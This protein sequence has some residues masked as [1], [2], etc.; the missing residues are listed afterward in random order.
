MYRV[1][2]K[3]LDDDLKT[4]GAADITRATNNKAV[5][6]AQRIIDSAVAGEYTVENDTAMDDSAWTNIPISLANPFK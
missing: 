1:F 6:H 3:F 2:V 4:Y 5:S